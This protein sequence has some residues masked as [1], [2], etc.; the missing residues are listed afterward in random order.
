MTHAVQRRHF[1]LRFGAFWLGAHCGNF[2]K[3]QRSRQLRHSRQLRLG[4]GLVEADEQRLEDGD[5]LE[6]L[7][8]LT[9]FECGHVKL[10]AAH[11]G[12]GGLAI[13]ELLNR[14]KDLPWRN[15]ESML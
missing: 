6:V 1:V 4:R 15:G 8:G 3:T 9:L 12:E 13:K 2:P 14:D 10:L 11:K 5:E 7:D